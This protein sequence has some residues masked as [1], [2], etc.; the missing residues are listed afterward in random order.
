S[1][2]DGDPLSYD[3]SGLPSGLVIDSNSGL[4]SGTIDPS[5]ASG[6]AYS[7]T[8]TVTDPGQPARPGQRG[9]RQRGSVAIGQRW[10]RLPADLHGQRA[11]GRLEHRPG[12]R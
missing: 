10:R 1:Q 6:T 8:V 11:A 9:G 3:A 12:Q 5:A 2:P 4:I 7:V